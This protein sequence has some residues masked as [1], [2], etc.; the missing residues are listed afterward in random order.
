[1]CH[2]CHNPGHVR[3][4]CKKSPNKNRRFQFVLYQESFKSA[5]TSVTTLV[6]HV[7]PTHFLFPLLPH[8]SLA[9]EPSTT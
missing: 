6:S 5:S 1:M 8:G 9:L 2:Y 4:N 3:H 7:K